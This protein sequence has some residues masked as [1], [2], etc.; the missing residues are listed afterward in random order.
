MSTLLIV[1]V[2]M[3]IA[4][5]LMSIGGAILGAVVNACRY[6]V[7]V[8]AGRRQAWCKRCGIMVYNEPEDQQDW[9]AHC[10]RL[11]QDHEHGAHGSDKE[12]GH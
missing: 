12:K 8:V 9:V 3:G 1:V 5:M 2:S 10:A 7:I 11:C 6:H 4:A